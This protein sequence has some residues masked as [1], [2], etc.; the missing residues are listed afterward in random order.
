[1]PASVD[2]GRLRPL[3][4]LRTGR[5]SRRPR[6][7]AGRPDLDEPAALAHRA[8]EAEQLLPA[9]AR[10]IEVLGALGRERGGRDQPILAGHAHESLRGQPRDAGAELE[11]GAASA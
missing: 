2:E 7:D 4:W 9:R 3:A 1:M 5:S 6:S 10:R 8:E 11:P